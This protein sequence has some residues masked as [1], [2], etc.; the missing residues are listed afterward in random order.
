M[1]YIPR[2]DN[3]RTIIMSAV[4][5]RC[6]RINS[7]NDESNSLAAYRARERM[8]RNCCEKEDGQRTFIRQRVRQWKEGCAETS[9]HNQYSARRSQ[10]QVCRLVFGLN[11]ADA[12]VF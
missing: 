3:N 12:R 2:Y 9:P 1:H 10:V 8:N 11:A 7:N 4:K 5:V 6:S